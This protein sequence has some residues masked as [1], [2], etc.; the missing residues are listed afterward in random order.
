MYAAP[1]VVNWSETLQAIAIAPNLQASAITSAV[2]AITGS[3]IISGSATAPAQTVGEASSTQQVTL[4]FGA[5]GTLADVSVVTQGVAGLDFIAASGGSCAP[6]TSYAAG[7]TCTV[8]YTFKPLAPGMRYGA[9]ALTD[10]LHHELATTM[11]SGM[12]NGQFAT[13]TPGTASTYAGQCNPAWDPNYFTQFL[14]CYLSPPTGDNVPATSAYL[15]APLSVTASGAGDLFILDNN[16]ST[17]RKVNTSGLINTVAG[18]GNKGYGGDGGP[19]TQASIYSTGYYYGGSVAEDGAGIY[20]LR[21]LRIKWFGRYRRLQGS[22][23]QS[24][25][26][27]EYLETC[28]RTPATVARLQKQ[29]SITR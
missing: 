13:L 8:A 5:S 20:I 25:A 10:K 23:P 26:R 28:L 4:T 29:R 27:P 19:A 2:Y 6:G 15:Y 22:L 11:L 7:Q 24:Q 18:N 9:V 16:G 21:I 12:G 17:V 3:S 14:G 1:V